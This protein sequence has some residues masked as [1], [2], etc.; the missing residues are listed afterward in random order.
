MIPQT[1]LID[2]LDRLFR[3]LIDS[4]IDYYGIWMYT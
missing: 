3:C 2:H 4:R 1:L